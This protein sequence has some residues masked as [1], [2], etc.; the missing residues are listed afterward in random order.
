MKELTSDCVDVSSVLENDIRLLFSLYQEYYGGTSYSLFKSDFLKKDR[1]FL[2]FDESE[3]VK[4]FSTL[5]ISDTTVAGKEIC[6]LFSGD[7]II[8]REYW[9]TQALT[10]KFLE[11]SAEIYREKQDIPIYWLL[12]VK[13]HRTYRYLKTFYYDYYPAFNGDADTEKEFR[14]LA[15]ELASRRFGDCYDTRSGIVQFPESHGHL[16][17]AWADIPEKDLRLPDVRFFLEKNPGYRN[18]DELVCL[19]RIAPENY[20]PFA[21]R[22]FEAA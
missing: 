22:I 9:G 7:T 3:T 13:G 18:G 16:Q 2:M 4:G 12:I 17:D 21:R 11:I 5:E 10:R 14:E 15:N 8:D 19:C 20:K 1:V 6:V